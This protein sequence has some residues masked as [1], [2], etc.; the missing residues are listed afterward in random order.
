M[1]LLVWVKCNVTMNE[2]KCAGG[3]VSPVQEH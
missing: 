2:Q 3:F 1:N